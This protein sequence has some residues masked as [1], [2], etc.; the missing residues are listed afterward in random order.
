MDDEIYIFHVSIEQVWCT[1]YQANKKTHIK[2]NYDDIHSE[3]DDENIHF[4]LT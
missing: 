1:F 3:V 4:T 2:T